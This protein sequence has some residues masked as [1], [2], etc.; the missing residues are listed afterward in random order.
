MCIRDSLGEEDIALRADK[1]QLTRVFNNLIKNAIQACDENGKLIIAI[2]KTSDDHG[3]VVVTFKDN[4]HG[5][6]DETSKKIFVPNFTTKNSGSGLGLAM[7][8]SILEQM[9][10]SISFESDVG[11]GTEFKIEF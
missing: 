2:D 1:D 11:V 4:G 8:K 7:V 3:K 10:A 9:G 5:I 6:D